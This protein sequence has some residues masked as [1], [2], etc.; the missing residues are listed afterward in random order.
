[1]GESGGA[2]GG[3]GWPAGADMQQC[4]GIEDTFPLKRC[5]TGMRPPVLSLR[6]ISRQF[7]F[8]SESESSMCAKGASTV[9]Q[10]CLPGTGPVM[11]MVPLPVKTT[12]ASQLRFGPRF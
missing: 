6:A 8:G 1:M 9:G 3:E 12:S 11:C 10:A 7:N 2:D 4:T 5:N